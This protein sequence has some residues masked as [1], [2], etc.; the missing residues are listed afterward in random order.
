MGQ[1]CIAAPGAE[2]FQ[3]QAA[4][5]SAATA[6]IVCEEQVREENAQHGA[7]KHHCGVTEYDLERET[8]RGA[9]PRH[10]SSIVGV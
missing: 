3:V 4:F 5:A 7:S 8:A 6:G 9:K 1:L 2:R 10:R